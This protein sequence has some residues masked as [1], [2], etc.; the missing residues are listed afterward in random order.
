MQAQTHFCIRLP[1]DVLVHAWIIQLLISTDWP[2]YP[3]YPIQTQRHS[4]CYNLAD[5]L[6][7][8]KQAICVQN[9][10]EICQ[11]LMKIKYAKILICLLS[12][13][14]KISTFLKVPFTVFC[15]STFTHKHTHKHAD[16]QQALTCCSSSE[17]IRCESPESESLPKT[18]Y[19]K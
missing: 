19:T 1:S 14:D 9:K 18:A 15:M 17:L 3:D 10:E 8:I 4:L 13:C 2:C 11:N 7:P 12:A 16:I 5:L 6:D